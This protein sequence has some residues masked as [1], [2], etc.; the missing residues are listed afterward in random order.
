MW[1]VDL[2]ILRQ[3]SNSNKA[4]PDE[5]WGYIPRKLMLMVVSLCGMSVENF[6]S[7][8]LEGDFLLEGGGGEHELLI[9][10]IRIKGCKI[11]LNSVISRIQHG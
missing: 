3:I 5:V 4:V 8:W 6:F 10:I 1:K 11:S 7:P 9:F 2:Y